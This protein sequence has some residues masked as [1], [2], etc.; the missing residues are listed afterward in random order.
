MKRPPTSPDPITKHGSPRTVTAEVAS[1]TDGPGRARTASS[2]GASR[3][4]P[5]L[6]SPRYE[7]AASR[8]ASTIRAYPVQR[9]RLPFMYSATCSRV[10]CGCSARSAVAATSMP[11]V[12]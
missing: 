1:G 11:G 9:Q 4:S 5:G 8:I 12:Q 2:R 10:G 6:G 3:L 7:P